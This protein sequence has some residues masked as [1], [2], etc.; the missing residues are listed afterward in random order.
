MAL[1][2]FTRFEN[3][4]PYENARDSYMRACQLYFGE[5]LQLDMLYGLFYDLSYIRQ[6]Q[7]YKQPVQNLP[8]TSEA[9]ATARVE[10]HLFSQHFTEPDVSKFEA[11]YKTTNDYWHDV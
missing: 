9:V 11:V 8:L 7:R 10:T 2:Q 5:G 4:L 6:S 1:Y 3:A